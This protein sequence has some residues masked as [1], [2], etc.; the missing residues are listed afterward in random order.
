MA[1][2]SKLITP[3][4][5]EAVYRSAP[6]RALKRVVVAHWVL[7]A[8]GPRQEYRLSLSAA[9]RRLGVGRRLAAD[10]VQL[11]AAMG[12]IGVSAPA[13][14]ALHLEVL[15]EAPERQWDKDLTAELIERWIRK[16][17]AAGAWC[18]LARMMRVPVSA[19]TWRRFRRSRGDRPMSG[20]SGRVP[21]RVAMASEPYSGGL[22]PLRR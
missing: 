6:R 16:R 8:M 13:G 14:G 10:A 18:E 15:V 7:A 12:I 17:G 5:S 21:G 3:A 1:S 20:R 22:V 11:L 2:F 9:G 19:S 4:V